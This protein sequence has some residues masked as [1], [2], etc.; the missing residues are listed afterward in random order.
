MPWWQWRSD[1]VYD[2]RELGETYVNAYGRASDELVSAVKAPTVIMNNKL[3][4]HVI[5]AVHMR[6]MLAVAAAARRVVARCR[7]REMRILITSKK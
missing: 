3:K 6:W 2:M 7:R 5:H 4:L 1:L